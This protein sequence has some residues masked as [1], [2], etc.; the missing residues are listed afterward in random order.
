[1]PRKTAVFSKCIHA[2]ILVLKANDPRLE[3]GIYRGTLQRIRDYFRTHGNKDITNYIMSSKFLFQSIIT[4]V[5][6][7]ELKALSK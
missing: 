3:E 4:H 1:M 2:V 5:S 6:S 7:S